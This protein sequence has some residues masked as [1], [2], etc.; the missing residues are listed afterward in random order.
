ML[1]SLF[2]LCVACMGMVAKNWGLS[3]PSIQFAVPTQVWEFG[4]LGL[5]LT[6]CHKQSRHR[7]LRDVQE[8]CALEAHNLSEH[9]TPPRRRARRWVVKL[10]LPWIS[11]R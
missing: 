10:V 4:S 11:L 1:L 2:L 8:A 5:G 9:W 7:A 6:R 3:V